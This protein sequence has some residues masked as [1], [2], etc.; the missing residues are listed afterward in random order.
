MDD[1]RN[2]IIGSSKYVNYGRIFN[3]SAINLF[4]GSF[5]HEFRETFE[6]KKIV[7]IVN[8]DL[9]LLMMDFDNKL[10]KLIFDYPGE[11]KA[12]LVN[13]LPY[14]YTRYPGIENECSI[15]FKGVP[16]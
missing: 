14:E 11:D 4:R 7:E 12:S 6:Y 15:L 3:Y 5:E 8:P 16:Q 9:S 2:Y 10:R 1:T 13:K